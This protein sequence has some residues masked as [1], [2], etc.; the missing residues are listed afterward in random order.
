MAKPRTEMSKTMTKF[1]DDLHL[2]E[3]GD[4]ELEIE[5]N[6]KEYVRLLKRALKWKSHDRLEW[7]CEYL[8]AEADERTETLEGCKAIV[9]ED[10]EHVQ[11]GL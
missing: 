5:A 9:K 1:F 11:R 3:F 8:G 4:D 7:V 2:A 6:P 10:I